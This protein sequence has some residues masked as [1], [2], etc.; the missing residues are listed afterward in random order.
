MRYHGGKYRLASWI[1]QFFPAHTTY[2][3]PFGGAAGVLLQ[4]PRSY[5]EVYNDLDQDIVNVFRVLRDPQLAAALC[6]QMHH[7]PYARIEFEEAYLTTSDPVERAR[8]TLIRAEMG[9]GSAGATKNRTG[10]R[11]DTARKYATSSHLW[12]RLPAQ[13]KQFTDRLRGVLIENRP[14]LKV[15]ENHDRADTLFFIDPP[16]R[17]DTRKLR[18]KSSCY[19]YEMTNE[20]H[21]ELLQAMLSI[22]GMAIISGY[23]SDQYNDTLLGW[24]R[25]ATISRI[26]AG[27]G[28]DQR[29]EIVWLNPACSQNKPQ[30]KLI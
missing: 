21:D 29:T 2:V 19:N 18:P 10:F 28:T 6:Y 26:S 22:K 12:P 15:I 27:R 16:Y 13:L 25:H 30:E 7:T 14:A 24:E 8:R 17:L 11:T 3:E 1:M 9:F 23:D 4:K 5:S 20:Q